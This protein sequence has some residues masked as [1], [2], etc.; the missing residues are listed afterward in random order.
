MFTP[1][2]DFQ[3]ETPWTCW[4]IIIPNSN[5]KKGVN[6]SSCVLAKPKQLLSMIICLLKRWL[7]LIKPEDLFDLLGFGSAKASIL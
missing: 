2:R 1:A 4:R 6:L 3:L 7:F 5:V